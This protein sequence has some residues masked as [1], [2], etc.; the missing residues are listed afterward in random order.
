MV[1]QTWS[2][3]HISDQ[4]HIFFPNLDIIYSLM[5]QA[6]TVLYLL[7][8]NSGVVLC[9]KVVMCSM[10]ASFAAKIC[11]LMNMAENSQ[12]RIF[13]PKLFTDSTSCHGF[14]CICEAKYGCRASIFF[15]CLF[16]VHVALLQ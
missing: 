3:S 5:V 11:G 13:D 16:I 4:C 1:L 15:T 6:A 8:K 12:F 9:I 14:V 10:M 2:K 7:A